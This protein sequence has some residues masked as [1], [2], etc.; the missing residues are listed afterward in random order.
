MEGKLYSDRL[1]WAYLGFWTREGEE[2]KQ[3]LID[4]LK[5]FKAKL[6]CVTD[7][8]DSGN[9][10]KAVQEADRLLKKQKDFPCAKARFGV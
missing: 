6:V 8:L 1:R 9:N 5:V 4:L 10:K 2:I 3:D 7:C